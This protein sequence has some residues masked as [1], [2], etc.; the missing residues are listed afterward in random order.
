M[1]PE[2]F[3][4]LFLGWDRNVSGRISQSWQGHQSY[5]PEHQTPEMNTRKGTGGGGKEGRSIQHDC[6]NHPIY[7]PPPPTPTQN[8]FSKC[9][10]N[11]MVYNNVKL[12][13]RHAS[14]HQK[15][16]CCFPNKGLKIASP[17]SV[18]QDSFVSDSL[19]VS[20]CPHLDEFW[21]WPI[22]N[23]LHQIAVGTSTMNHVW[24]K[25]H[26]LTKYETQEPIICVQ[27]AKDI[28]LRQQLLQT[29]REC[30]GETPPC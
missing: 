27:L 28:S 12:W 8:N 13:T 17:S 21:S 25:K 7:P 29:A 3:K 16:S 5:V 30:N 24:R 14:Q 19:V 4:P 20:T 1:P 10:S 18:T 9:F 11:G 6:I 26:K 15:L 22:A 23:P 2:W